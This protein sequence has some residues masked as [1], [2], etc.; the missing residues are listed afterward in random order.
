MTFK[1]EHRLTERRYITAVGATRLYPNQTVND[2]ESAM[3]VN[4]T[5]FNS[6][7]GDG[8]TSPPLDFFAT[9]GGKS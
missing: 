1:L 6:E 7:T 2:P 3:Q 4:L 9:G 8:G 5:A